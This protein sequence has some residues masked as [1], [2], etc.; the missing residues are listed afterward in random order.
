M[1]DPLTF[2]RAAPADVDAII[3]MWDGSGLGA[4]VEADRIEALERLREDD[5]FFIVGVDDLGAVRSSAMGCYDNHRGW[6]KRVVVDPDFRRTGEGN[7]LIIELERR[8]RDAGITKLRMAVWRQN[9]SAGA[10]WEAQGYEELVD[11]RYFTK[12]LET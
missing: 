12:S 3:E 6:V 9:E 11:I 5:G 2:R 7:R 10:F 4:G 1:T 8:F